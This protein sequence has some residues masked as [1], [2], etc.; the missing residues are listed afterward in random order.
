MRLRLLET[1]LEHDELAQYILDLFRAKA[2][3]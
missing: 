1:E 3:S 2:G